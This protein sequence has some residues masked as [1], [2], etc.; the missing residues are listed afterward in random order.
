MKKSKFF[1]LA[2]AVTLGIASFYGKKP[3]FTSPT[4]LWAA[5]YLTLFSSGSTSVLTLTK[6]GTNVNVTTQF[7]TVSGS[8]KTILT[9][10]G[11]AKVYLIK[12]TG[13]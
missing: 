6:D 4:K 7:K 10:S 9:S 13:Y 3:Y 5:G 12:N 11:G 2:G 1:I 8:F